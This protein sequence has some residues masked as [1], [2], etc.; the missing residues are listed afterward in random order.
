MLKPF[1]I[2]M[3]LLI[4]TLAADAEQLVSDGPYRLHYIAMSSTE[5]TPEIAA[6][7]GVTRSARRGVLVLNLQ[8]ADQGLTSLPHAA[9]GSIRNLIGQDR[10]GEIREVREQDAIYS[11][12]EFRY[13]HL[14]T[15]RF[16]FA[17]TT[18]DRARPIILKFAQQFYTPGR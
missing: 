1:L 2:A 4:T 3:S 16:D 17:V 14:E 10:L 11:I 15:M 5:L 18:A 13:S 6:A 9:D 7:Y 12:I 8:H